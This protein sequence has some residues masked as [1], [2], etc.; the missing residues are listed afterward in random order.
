MRIKNATK[1]ATTPA[2]FVVED[3]SLCSLFSTK[4]AGNTLQVYR[5]NKTASR[6]SNYVASIIRISTYLIRMKAFQF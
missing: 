3:L 5:L 4:Y 6:V 2:V 1:R